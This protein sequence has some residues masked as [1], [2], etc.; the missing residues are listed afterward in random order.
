M[1]EYIPN[2]SSLEQASKADRLSRIS[3]AGIL[4]SK[5]FLISGFGVRE[6][7][8]ALKDIADELC[9]RHP[10][11]IGTVLH[12]SAVKGY[13]N[14]QSDIDGYLFIAEEKLELVFAKRISGGPVVIVEPIHYESII[15]DVRESFQSIKGSVIIA[16]LVSKEIIVEECQADV[17]DS[18]LVKMF[19]LAL[20]GRI[21]EY[22]E[23]IISTL[24]SMGEQGKNNW[25]RIMEGL[26]QSESEGLDE[27]TKLKRK[28]LYP[29]TLEEGRR[30]FLRKPSLR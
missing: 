16:T 19:L 5:R 27:K 22:R 1:R 8:Y 30:Y 14:S 18:R 3:D 23:L 20:N 15:E 2:S 26:W 10:E 17:I 12:G 6:K 7:L 25:S 11:I 4:E 21:N 24:E 9:A 28:D 13:A 29:K